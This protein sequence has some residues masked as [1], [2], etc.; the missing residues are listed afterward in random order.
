MW[1]T[2]VVSTPAV[3]LD[4]SFKWD[5]SRKKNDVVMRNGNQDDHCDKACDQPQEDRD[6]KFELFPTAVRP[7]TSH[8]GIEEAIPMLSGGQGGEAKNLQAQW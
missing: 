5:T 4:H 6:D 2:Q 1:I 7:V 3:I 8:K